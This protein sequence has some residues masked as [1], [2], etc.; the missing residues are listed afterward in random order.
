MLQG[1]SSPPSFRVPSR[2]LLRSLWMGTPEQN[3][4]SNDVPLSFESL[5]RNDDSLN[6]QNT[7]GQSQWTFGSKTFDDRFGNGHVSSQGVLEGDA[8]MENATIVIKKGEIQD[9]WDP[10]LEKECPGCGSKMKIPRVFEASSGALTLQPNFVSS[11]NEDRAGPSFVDTY[12][13]SASLSPRPISKLRLN[14]DRAGPEIVDACS[15]AFLLISNPPKERLKATKKW[16][17]KQ[18]NSSKSRQVH[19]L[20]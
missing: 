4:S 17:Q 6:K 14:I 13:S 2:S 5:S 20:L 8:F 12:G 15:G 16:G 1:F 18:E 10:S 11:H 3:R 19:L 9:L 7:L